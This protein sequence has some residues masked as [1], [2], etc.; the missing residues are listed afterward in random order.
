MPI[1]PCDRYQ[2]EKPGKR[3]QWRNSEPGVCQMC[4]GEGELSEE[5]LAR[6]TEEQAEG[7][8]GQIDSIEQFA[9]NCLTKAPTHPSPFGQ[10]S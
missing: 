7:I 6:K 8:E 10:P 9:G 4:G 5:D 1:L 3:T 2:M